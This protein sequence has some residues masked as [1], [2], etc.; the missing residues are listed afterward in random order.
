MQENKRKVLEIIP[1]DVDGNCYEII[2]FMCL[3]MFPDVPMRNV[4]ISGD[5]QVLRIT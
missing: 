3:Q 4:A 5:D 1:Y 2:I